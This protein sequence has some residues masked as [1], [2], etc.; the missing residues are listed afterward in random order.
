MGPHH[1]EQLEFVPCGQILQDEE[2]GELN[3]AQIFLIL[4]V[5]ETFPTVCVQLASLVF[6]VVVVVVVVF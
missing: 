2:Q 1:S 6:V 4:Q 3:P 5:K